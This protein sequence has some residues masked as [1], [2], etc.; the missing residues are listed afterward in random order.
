MTGYQSDGEGRSTGEGRRTGEGVAEVATP[1]RRFGR[2]AIML[3]AAAVGAGIAADLV[4]TEPASAANGNPV[5]LGDSNSATSSTVVSTTAGTGLQGEASTNGQSGLAGI[6]TSPDGGHGTYGKST[7][8]T[9]AYGVTTGD[10]IGQSGVYGVDG[11]S[12]GGYGVR[13]SSTWGY[14]SYGVSTHGTGVYGQTSE[15]LQSGVAGVDDSSGGFGVQGTSA[16]GW[17]VH[18]VITGSGLA[19]V[20]GNDN[21]S[22]GSFGVEGIS[23]NGTGVCGLTEADG[24]SGVAGIDSSTSGGH[25]T[26]GRS[27]NGTGAY[28]TTGADGQS[29]VEGVDTSTN[30]GFGVQGISDTGVGVSAT[31]TSGAALKVNGVADF[32]R[33]GMATVVGTTTTAARTVNVTGVSLTASSLILATPQGNVAGVAVAGVVPSVAGSSFV[34][35]LTKAITVSLPIAWFVVG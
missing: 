33:S 11:S 12:D 18:G 16:N 17:G 19:A 6:D 30:G 28:G 2:R 20:L 27:S 23:G 24:Q 3:G 35:H 32:S 21:T 26:F 9:G 22:A 8:G 4:A 29:G 14:G 1:S 25:G 7:N 13:G 15:I 10:T 34:I 5:K 31:S